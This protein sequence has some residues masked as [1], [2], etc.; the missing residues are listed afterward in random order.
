MGTSDPYVRETSPL[1]VD[2]QMD[3]L[4]NALKPL[5]RAADKAEAKLVERRE[6]NFGAYLGPAAHVGWG[7]KYRHAVKARRVLKEMGVDWNE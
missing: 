2:A 7:I 3:R 1:L 4:I 6:H 5:A